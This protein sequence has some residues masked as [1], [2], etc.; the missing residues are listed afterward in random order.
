MRTG[1]QN[2]QNLQI[3]SL[4]YGTKTF[5]EEKSHVRTGLPMKIENLKQYHILEGVTEIDTHFL[6]IFY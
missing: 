4:T 1:I 2:G 6:F 3:P 5:M